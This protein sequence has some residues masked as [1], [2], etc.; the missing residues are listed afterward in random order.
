MILSRLQQREREDRPVRVGVVGA[1]SMGAGLAARVFNTPGM[2]LV[3]ICDL[4]VARGRAAVIAAGAEPAHGADVFDPRVVI[5]GDDALAFLS[6]DRPALEIDVFVESTNTVVAAA[7]HCLAAIDRSAHVVLMNAEVDLAFGGMLAARA[8]E[9]GVVVSS[10]AGDQHGVLK[11]MIDEIEMWGLRI[12]QIGNIKGFLDRY[13]TADGLRAEAAARQLNPVQCCAYTDGT[14]LN[15]EMAVIANATGAVPTVRGM[16]GPRATHVSEVL[17]LFDFA[18]YPTDRAI[19]DYVLGAEPGGG[20][21][22]VGFCDEPAEMRYLQYYKLGSGPYYLFYRPYHLC[23]LETTY[24]I[25]L[26]ALYGEAVRTASSRSRLRC[27]CLRQTA[28]RRRRTTRAWHRRRPGVRPH[29]PLRRGRIRWTAS[30][31]DAGRDGPGCGDLESRGTEGR[32][33]STER[34]RIPRPPLAGTDAV[35]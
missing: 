8:A 35:T 31:L 17:R 23:H 19:V 5:V 30:D 29:R 24:A 4:D 20:V 14:K 21:Y 16:E 33:H 27:L 10:D 7:R 3:W 32:A 11:R 1:G 2:R 12:V 13:Q 34:C 28:S 25:G 6:S 9:R 26:A 18:S 15:I 22:V